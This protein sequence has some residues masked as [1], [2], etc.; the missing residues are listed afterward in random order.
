MIISLTGNMGVG[1]DTMADYM[2]EKYGFVKVSMADPFKRIAKEVYEFSDEQLWGP[3]EER[4]RDDIRYPR[5]DGTYLSARIATQLLGNE[6]SRLAYPETWIVY[7]KRIVAKVEKGYFYSEKKGVYEIPG[8]KSEYTG[9]IVSSCRFEN[10]IQ[11]IKDMGGIAVRLTRPA[12]SVKGFL[13]TGLQNHITETE[14]LSLSDSFFDYVLEVPEGIGAFYAAIDV[15][16]QKI[17]EKQFE[18]ATVQR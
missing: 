18:A 7:M 11:S 3:S 5:K 2:V 12:L 15:F 4:N 16:M 9:I 8:K 6:L 14:Q 13:T 10:E 1:K 17:Q